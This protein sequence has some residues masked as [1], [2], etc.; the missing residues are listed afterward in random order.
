[1]WV[2]S[3]VGLNLVTPCEELLPVG[4]RSVRCEAVPQSNERRVIAPRRRRSP[5]EPRV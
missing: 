1:M 4:Y 5:G 3:E 2:I